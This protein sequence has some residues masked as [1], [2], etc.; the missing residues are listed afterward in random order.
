[1]DSKVVTYNSASAARPE[2]DLFFA[3]GSPSPLSAFYIRLGRLLAVAGVP[4]RPTFKQALSRLDDMRGSLVLGTAFRAGL[5]IEIVAAD[6]E[7]GSC[8]M[9]ANSLSRLSGLMAGL[10][11]DETL[12][13]L[14]RS[15]SLPFTKLAAAVNDPGNADMRCLTEMFSKT[16]RVFRAVL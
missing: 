2:A 12:E 1:M 5:E 9:K 11:L 4:L 10:F 15:T 3:F 8:R 14:S 7:G 13:E 6:D 16:G